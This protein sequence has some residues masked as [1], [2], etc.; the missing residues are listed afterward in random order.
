[1]KR[2]DLIH[3]KYEYLF[4]LPFMQQA[5]KGYKLL[6]KPAYKLY[7]LYLDRGLWY[8]FI[9]VLGYVKKGYLMYSYNPFSMGQGK[10]GI[11]F[12]P[13]K[14]TLKKM[15]ME[16]YLEEDR[17]FIQNYLFEQFSKMGY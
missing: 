11:I 5:L 13:T 17:E 10:Y 9:I 1:M 6:E 16:E 8:G 12:N 7:G 3:I 14:C 4:Q 15:K 2:I